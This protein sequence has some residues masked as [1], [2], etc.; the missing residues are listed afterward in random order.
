MGLPDVALGVAG[1]STPAIAS[2]VAGLLGVSGIVA[3][4]LAPLL[5]GSTQTL[6][7]G[8]AGLMLLGAA[9]A[10]MHLRLTPPKEKAVAG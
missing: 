1:V 9:A 3:G 2:V 8:M 10:W 7:F 6:A 5:W 4:V